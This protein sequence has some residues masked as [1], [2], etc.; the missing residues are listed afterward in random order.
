MG[1]KLPCSGKGLSMLVTYDKSVVYYISASN[2]L[3]GENIFSNK[4]VKNFFSN[5]ISQE[6]FAFLKTS[7]VTL[8]MN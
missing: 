5:Y 2:W 8:I 6:Y 4:V 1:K 3:L 7:L